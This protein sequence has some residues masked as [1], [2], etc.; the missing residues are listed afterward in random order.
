MS[1]LALSVALFMA[2]IRAECSEAL[3]SRSTWYTW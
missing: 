1:C 2:T 3:A